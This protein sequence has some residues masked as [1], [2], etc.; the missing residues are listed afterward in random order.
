MSSGKKNKGA[1]AAKARRAKL[2]AAEREAKRKRTKKNLK[3]ALTVA[4]AV[5]AVAAI[6]I[7]A[8]FIYKATGTELRKKTAAESEHFS[9]NGAEMAYFIYDAYSD[10]QG[11]F[12]NYIGQL[13]LDTSKPL[14]KQTYYGDS[15]DTW[16]D[17]FVHEASSTVNDTLLLCEKAYADGVELDG[18]EK[19]AVNEMASLF[20]LKKC[21]NGVKRADVESAMTL[22]ALAAKYKNICYDSYGITEGDID[23]YYA[24]HKTDF[25]KAGYKRYTFEYSEDGGFDREAAMRA[26]EKIA[27]AANA[28]EFE[29]NLS[30][31]LKDL[32][33]SDGDIEK[34]LASVDFSDAY[35]QSEAGE[36]LFG[37]AVNDTK[38]IDYPTDRQVSVYMLTSSPSPDTERTVNVRNIMLDSHSCGSTKKAAETAER[39][40]EKWRGGT[41]DE[42][43]FAK[44]ARLYS[45]DFVTASDGGLYEGVTEGSTYDEFDAWCFDGTRKYGDCDV[46]AVTDGIMTENISGYYILF[47]AGEGLPVYK[48]QIKAQIAGERFISM[49]NSL[50]N[51]VE[52]NL[53]DNIFDGISI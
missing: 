53:Y 37:A 2:A 1:V 9:V 10:F 30:D 12:G 18:E 22:L 7:A 17:Y 23:E 26:A 20:E 34:A 25:D 44:L 3:T 35:S 5:A 47:F 45:G 41:A 21:G 32:G 48:A 29:K 40:F 4:A 42:N 50:A 24:S 43:Y 51:T 36:F 15:F 16:Y 31:V 27:R 28:G 13:G 11:Y 49:L 14:K 52:I 19:E 38:V 33:A 46:V 39:V 6:F 8:I